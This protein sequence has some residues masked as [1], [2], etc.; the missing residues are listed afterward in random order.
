M[1]RDDKGGDGGAQTHLLILKTLM[2]CELINKPEL[3]YD[4]I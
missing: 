2:P 3:K 4:S 1:V